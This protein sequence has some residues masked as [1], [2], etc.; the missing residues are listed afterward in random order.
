[1]Q[2]VIE[3]HSASSCQRGTLHSRLTLLVQYA[4]KMAQYRLCTAQHSTVQYST[5]QHRFGRVHYSASWYHN[6]ALAEP[7]MLGQISAGTQRA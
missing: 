6:A 4:Q 7:G 1:M 2:H 5:V 3:Q